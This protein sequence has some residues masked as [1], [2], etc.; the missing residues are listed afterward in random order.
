VL[1]DL[2][3]LALDGGDARAAER[4]L[5]EA[6][7][8][9]PA[10]PGDRWWSLRAGVLLEQGRWQELL[11]ELAPLGDEAPPSLDLFRARAL[12]ALGNTAEARRR[13]DRAEACC[14]RL[15]LFLAAR[16]EIGIREGDPRGKADREEARAQEKTE[17]AHRQARRRA[18]GLARE[19][20]PPALLALAG[21][22]LNLGL[23]EEAYRSVR[24]AVA[25]A[26]RSPEALRRAADLHAA[27]EDVLLRV[28]FLRRLLAERP[29]DAAAKAELSAALEPF[30]TTEKR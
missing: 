3:S 4:C 13:L 14:S 2:A 28:H 21:E 15:P 24:L 5:G 16:A 29:R 26:P 19:A 9:A 1:L 27:P 25:L 23:R 11:D 18:G 7:A 20:A 10:A 6:A 17:R 22:A 30:L 12:A 8:L